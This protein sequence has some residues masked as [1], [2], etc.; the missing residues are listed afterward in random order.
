MSRYIGISPE[1]VLDGFAKKFLYGLR[2]NDD[3]ELFLIRIDQL[4]A[5]DENSIVINDQGSSEDNFADFEE[6]VDF[7]EGINEDR[8]IVHAN[9]RY[10]Q[11]K[12]D[13]RRLL[14]YIDA[15]TGQFVQLVSQ[16][17]QFEDGISTPGYGEGQDQNVL[18]NTDFTDAERE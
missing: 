4:G 2:R 13:D 3:G 11:L 16:G 6:G 17:H 5:G 15:I 9:L 7:L 18:A 10:P 8:N 1:K 12:W 14:F